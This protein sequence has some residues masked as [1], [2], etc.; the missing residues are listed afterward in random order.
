MAEKIKLLAIIGPTASG[1]TAL[2]IEIAKKF[3]GEIVAAD[4]RTVY[5]YLDIGTAKP[6]KQEQFGIPN[7]GFNLATPGQTYTVADFKKY[8]T[9][10][11]KEI[12]KR[13]KL[14]ILVGGSGLYIDAVLY[15]FVLVSSDPRLR[16]QLEKLSIAQLQSQI[17]RHGLVIPTNL[18]NK[19]YLIRTIERNETLL[20][21]TPLK[22]GT[23]IIG[24]NPSKQKLKKRIE[25]RASL[26]IEAGVEGEIQKAA[27]LYG[28]ESEAMTGGI[29]RA[30]K[31]VIMGIKSSNQG[32]T[33]YIAS[34]LHLAKRQMTWFKRNPDIHWFANTS[35]ALTWFEQVFG[36]KLR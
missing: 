17:I 35:L 7:W 9:Q 15:N 16:Q 20:G 1:K 29:Y 11:I 23:V 22:K 30:F 34:D 12:Q 8:T 13:H 18:R 2:A 14:P 6:N 36:G 10:K 21:K 27:N 19:R 32:L 31:D 5:K 33:D 25:S 3:D 4:S 24:I 28:W 26:M